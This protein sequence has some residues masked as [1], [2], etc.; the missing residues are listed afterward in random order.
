MAIIHLS[1][2]GALHQGVFTGI[3]R[4][5]ALE[6]MPSDSLFA[7]LVQTWA[8]QGAEVEARL[9]GFKVR[10]AEPPFT[11]TSAF[12]LAGT[13]RFFPAP[14]QLPG[15]IKLFSQESA[16][17]AKKVR[18]LSESILDDLMAGRDPSEESRLIHGGSAWISQ[19]EESYLRELTAAN[20]AESLEL[21]SYQIVPRVAVDR[22]SHASNLFHSGRVTFAPHCGLWFAIRGRLDWVWEALPHLADSGLGGLRS[23]GHGVFTCKK[24][25]QSLPEAGDGPG[26]LLSRYAPASLAEIEHG[27]K[28]EDSAYQLVS[29]GGWCQDDKGHAWR[30]R[31]V[32]L[33]AEGAILP[34]A[35]C[36]GGLVNVR[37]EKVQPWVGPPNVYRYGIPFFIPAG[38][39][40]EVV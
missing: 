22:Q 20:E 28:A 24:I 18:W 26:L 27:L 25:D 30:R 40:A 10:D 16:K 15:K 32:R 37:P 1:L 3:Q 4:E 35:A 13:V 19:R 23:S 31:T 12:P 14:P 9:A 8:E 39:L 17:K 5:K 29:V 36:R 33:V 2:K 7:A 21:W 11:I 38:K 34:M 6:W